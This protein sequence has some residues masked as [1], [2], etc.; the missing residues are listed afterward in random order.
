MLDGEGGDM[1]GRYEV[2]SVFRT[3]HEWGGY[4]NLG[5]LNVLMS[6]EGTHGPLRRPPGRAR[7]FPRP[8]SGPVKSPYECPI[9]GGRE[10]GQSARTP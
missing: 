4:F 7:L 10:A 8:R 9:E 2:G 1:G 6:K 3:L 5:C